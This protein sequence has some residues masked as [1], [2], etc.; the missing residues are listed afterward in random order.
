M[1]A[2]T[3]GKKKHNN[4]INNN[5]KNSEEKK[6]EEFDEKVF[7]DNYKF[8][9][10]ISF[11]HSEYI[12]YLGSQ[13]INKNRELIP[14]SELKHAFYVAILFSAVWCGPCSE[15]KP[16][17][18]E[19]YNKANSS[20]S[21]FTDPNEMNKNF[22]VVYVS[23]DKSIEQFNDYFDN[24]PFLAIP[25]SNVKLLLPKLKERLKVKH[26]PK[27]VIINREF[28][29]ISFNGKEHISDGIPIE[30]WKTIKISI[31]SFN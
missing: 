1:G 16:I 17:L 20:K 25:F 18:V 11:K 23:N 28:E 13:L 27:L 15:F 8:S 12:D 9:T 7:F 19:Y 21:L 30:N 22:E 2:C 5:I 31:S 6:D 3:S 14:T 4:V 10:K 24:L 26:I 29:I